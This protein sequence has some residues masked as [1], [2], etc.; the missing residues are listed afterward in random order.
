MADNHRCP[1]CGAERLDQ[2]P[3]GLCPKCLLENA[4]GRQTGQSADVTFAF[5]STHAGAVLESLARSVGPIPRILLPDTHPD[6]RGTH[7]VKPSSPEM[8]ALETR[9]DRYILFGE[10]A[11]GGMG[12]I[13]KGRDADLGRDLAV[14]VLLES[15]R[16]K[17]DLVR[18]FVEEAQIGG[19][20]QHPGI[21]PVYE[22]G[23]FADQRP[24]FTMKLIKGRTLG[25]LLNERKEP[26]EGFAR[27][28]DI[29]ER[30][31]Q[32]VAYS[33]ARGVIHRDLKPANIMVGGFGEVQVM[34]WGLAKVL[35]EGGVADE[36]EVPPAGSVSVIRTVRSDSDGDE[37]QAGSVLGTPAYM[38][39]EQAN[40]DIE[41]V[42]RRADVFGL[43]SVLCEIL[44]G[45]PAYTGK[46]PS[47]VLRKA[48]RGDTAEA[49][50]RLDACHAD[51]E[52]MA[53]AK[54]CLAAEADQ[55]PN[56]AGIVA[57]RISAYRASVAER[58]RAAELARVEAQA[59]A[60]EEVKRRALADQL[61]VAA[62]ARVKEERRRRKL[63]VGL[64]ASLL[65][66]VVVGGLGTTY[67][68][69]QRQ[70]RSDAVLRALTEATTLRDQ[71]REHPDDP[72]R[73]RVA[74]G[75][76]R[77]VERVL[78]PSANRDA[79][80]QFIRLRDEVESETA[81]TERDREL[82]ER[83]ADLR[84]S[85]A[86]EGANYAARYTDALRRAGY[87]VEGHSPAEVGTKIGKRP[88]PVAQFIAAV[89]DEAAA[90]WTTFSLDIE[91]A[92]ARALRL[93]EVAQ[94]ADANPWRHALR[95]A[96]VQP[97]QTARL[98]A[99]R[100]VSN[101]RGSTS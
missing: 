70:Q 40:G 9:G 56:D 2:A 88:K 67:F 13:L 57:D 75:T 44:T 36:P 39:P 32:T 45:Q 73:W 84:S 97:D 63:Q 55:R 74:L 53:L 77:Q 3:E 21:V 46:T 51:A 6:D 11:R 71:A 94:L 69:Q 95:K 87:D 91:T 34:D 41:Q 29:F 38:A 28:V 7:V 5:E 90:A 23:T 62:E 4:L 54:E 24:F 17:P 8:P 10:I 85:G 80:V 50:S 98:A 35:K 19:Q 48:A 31:C 37:S 15:H 64:A 78:S 14:K 49:L 60:E 66:L 101:R 42:D 26:E 12:A 83:L 16:G 65:A 76:I 96:L 30:V 47:E 92:R 22:L 89:L 86:A 25:A 33:H 59:R 79:W 82:L 43:G 72:A 52:L 58:L 1:N 20:L 61:T 68:V 81:T 27:F 18:R 100:D 93:T 99:L